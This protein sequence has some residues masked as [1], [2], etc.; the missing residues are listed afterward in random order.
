MP[1]QDAPGHW[2]W[3][4]SLDAMQAAPDHHRVLLEN[5]HV[6]V[7][8]GWVAPGDTVPVHTHRWPGVL[9]IVSSSHFVRFD[10]EGRLIYDSRNGPPLPAAGTILWG[11]ALTPHSLRNVGT[12]DIRV[13]AVETKR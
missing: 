3:P 2:P 12:T 1:D 7:L 9:H 11:A 5:E 4:E 13:I 10:A 6:R 8:E